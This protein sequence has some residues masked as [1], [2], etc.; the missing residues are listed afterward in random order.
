MATVAI[1]QPNFFPW[2]G[3]FDKIAKSDVFVILDSVQAS[4]TGGSWLNRVKLAMN[5]EARWVTAPIDRTFHGVKRVEDIEFTPTAWREQ[6]LKTLTSAYGRAEHYRATMALIEPLVNNPEPNLSRFNQ[7]AIT[8][9]ARRLKLH[10]SR[11]VLSSSL[12][13]ESTSNDL[14]IDITRAVGGRTYLCGGGASEYFDERPFEEAG[15]DV[16]YQNFVHPQYQQASSGQAIP[17]LSVIDA[18]MNC[19]M[20]VVSGWLTSQATPS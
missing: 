1:H 13:L 15:I 11:F 4:K 6:V 3:Y 2:L 18:I 14:L 20:D 8:T 10:S 16:R 17:G 7:L 5:G 9:L 12:H 19:G